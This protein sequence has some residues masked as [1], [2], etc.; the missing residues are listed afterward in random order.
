MMSLKLSLKFCKK[1]HQVNSL[2]SIPPPKKKQLTSEFLDLLDLL[3]LLPAMER[4]GSH[5]MDKDSPKTFLLIGVL[6]GI[7]GTITLGLI[8]ALILVTK[9]K[10]QS[11]HGPS[12]LV[13]EE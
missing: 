2:F 7:L 4:G 11:G 10:R 6:V 1:D 9:R 3:T 12:L 8:G 13:H 5:G